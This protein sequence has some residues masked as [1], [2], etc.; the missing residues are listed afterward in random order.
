MVCKVKNILSEKSKKSNSIQCIFSNKSK[1]WP[2]KSKKSKC[3]TWN[4]GKLNF[5]TK[6]LSKKS[7]F[8]QRSQRVNLV[9]S[10]S[11]LACFSTLFWLVF[12]PIFDKVKKLVPT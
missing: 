6:Y 1:F 9:S 10:K 12:Q 11:H 5:S 2:G 3:N 4:S 7:N 8:S